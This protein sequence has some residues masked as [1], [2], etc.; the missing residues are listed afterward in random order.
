MHMLAGQFLGRCLTNYYT[1]LKVV[2]VKRH[3]GCFEVGPQ[4]QLPSFGKIGISNSLAL[5]NLVPY[6]HQRL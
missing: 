4:S 5:L 1:V 2:S 3:V 6:L